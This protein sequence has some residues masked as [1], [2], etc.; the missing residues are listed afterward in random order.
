M[1]SFSYI[2]SV[3]QFSWH[4]KVANNELAKSSCI[5]LGDGEDGRCYLNCRMLNGIVYV[6][7]TINWDVSRAYLDFTIGSRRYNFGYSTC[8]H[9]C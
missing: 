4:N 5:I 6:V 7:D 8:K 3:V 2:S 1:V 9:L